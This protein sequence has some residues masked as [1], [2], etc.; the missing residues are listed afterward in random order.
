[1]LTEDTVLGLVDLGGQGGR[2]AP[3]GMDLLHQPAMRL[4]DFRLAGARIKPQDIVG[5]LRVHA[6]RTRRRALPLRPVSVEVVTPAGARAYEVL[7]VEWR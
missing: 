1:M 7:K 6:A 2:S 5:F 3:V 4:A